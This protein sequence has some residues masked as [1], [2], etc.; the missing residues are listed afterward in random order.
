MRA[1]MSGVR[2][3][4][5]RNP[6]P[7][8]ILAN[9]RQ[10]QGTIVGTQACHDLA[11]RSRRQARQHQ[12]QAHVRRS[13]EQRVYYGP[14]HGFAP[15]GV[16]ET[17]PQPGPTIRI[18]QPTHRADKD[19]ALDEV[20]VPRQRTRPRPTPARPACARRGTPARRLCRVDRAGT[21]PLH[22]AGWPPSSVARA[23]APDCLSRRC[24]LACPLWTPSGRKLNKDPPWG[25]LDESFRV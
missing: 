12:P 18:R 16:H 10:Q 5:L 22:P 25:P 4:S 3:R 24:A 8:R 23:R 21:Q 13:P 20:R 15:C 6:R 17:R 9:K 14:C 11:G 19:Q 2:R 1:V 7:E